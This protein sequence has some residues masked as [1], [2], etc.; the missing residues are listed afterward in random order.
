M[1]KAILKMTLAAA[2]LSTALLVALP[3]TAQTNL[4]LPNVTAGETLSEADLQI[5]RT[6]LRADKRKVT[7]ETLSLTEAEAAKFWPI[8]DRYIAELTV[9][10]NTKYAL[11]K[12]YSENFG[13]FD[14]AEASK[15]ISRWLDVDVKA[16]TLRK[17]YVPMVSKVLPGIKAASFFQIDRRLAMLI[18]LSLASQLPILQTQN[19]K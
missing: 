9:I 8:Y 10:N 16:D 18:N 14:N 1:S 2:M 15:F 7:A 12:E 13:G 4:G 11:I 3:A 17:K 6:N 5:I 19:D